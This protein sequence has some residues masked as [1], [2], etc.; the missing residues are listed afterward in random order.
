MEENELATIK[1]TIEELLQKMTIRIF[2]MEVK[3]SLVNNKECVNVDI[4]IEE[5]QILIGQNG[6][7]LFELSRLLMVV[8]N[9]KL[10]GKVE[11]GSF[12]VD[13]DIND[14]KKKKNEYLKNLAQELAEQVVA[15]KEN[16]I[17][18]TMSP[19]ERRI[20]HSELAL[21]SDVVTQSQGEG[22]DRHVVIS[23]K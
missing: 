13:L 18:P 15:T 8:L 6:Q 3:T 11:G 4:T 16:K 14:Y 22:D 19:Y 17:L 23:P 12:Y 2:A 10:A 5:P 7:T 21:R 20:I 9:K 1:Q